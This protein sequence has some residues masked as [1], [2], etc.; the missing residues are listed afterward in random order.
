MTLTVKGKQLDIGDSLRTHIDKALKEIVGKYFSHPIEAQV[1]LSKE[2]HLFDADISVHAGQGIVLQSDCKAPDPY[3]AFDAAAD[4]IAR[5]LLRHKGRLNDV[6]HRDRRSAAEVAESVSHFIL[7]PDKEEASKSD[8]TENNPVIVAEM[9]TE[10]EN[11]TV[12]EAVMR[13]D[14]GGL[15][16]LM[17]RNRSHGGFNMIYRR[18]DGHI[19][20][21]D[22]AMQPSAEK[23]SKRSS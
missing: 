4:R 17:F 16:A 21:V 9:T 20:W 14:L 2:A 5:R 6:H 22:P 15:S 19:G 12:G 13:L 3:A 8:V 18:R 23:D 10:I 7:D 11:L 1:T